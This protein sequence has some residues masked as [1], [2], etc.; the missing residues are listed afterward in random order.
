MKKSDLKK[1]IA[2]ELIAVLREQEKE[3]RDRFLGPTGQEGDPS[4]DPIDRLPPDPRF[5]PDEFDLKRPD[6]SDI[7]D[8]GG[9]WSVE[10]HCTAIQKACKAI[11]SAMQEDVDDQKDGYDS[12]IEAGIAIVRDIT[13][14][15]ARLAVNRGTMTGRGYTPIK[16]ALK[17]LGQRLERLG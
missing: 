12:T 3:V 4:I 17:F 10:E 15:L 6:P 1:L 13:S 16:G 9:D 2:E 14:H 7:K 8:P 5:P 11:T